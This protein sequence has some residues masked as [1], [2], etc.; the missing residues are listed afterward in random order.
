MSQQLVADKAE[1][2][3]RRK[4]NSL[5]WTA[6]GAAVFGWLGFSFAGMPWLTVAPTFL[7][8]YLAH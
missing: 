8:W 1:E 7:H 6:L 4:L 2:S 5:V 3:W